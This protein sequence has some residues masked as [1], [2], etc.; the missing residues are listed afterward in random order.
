MCVY[1]GEWSAGFKGRYGVRESTESGAKYEGTWTTGLQDGYGVE[2]YAD[3]GA[4]TSTSTSTSTLPFS[5]AHYTA[6]RSHPTAA[7]AIGWHSLALSR[8]ISSRL[9]GEPR[10]ASCPLPSRADV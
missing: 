10:L 1:S 6:Q 7:R 4:L 2:T 8:L 3:G 5:Q 9:V